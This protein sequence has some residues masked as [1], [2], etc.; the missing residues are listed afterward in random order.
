MRGSGM[1]PIYPWLRPPMKTGRKLR[2][3]RDALL[4]QER[5]AW[6]RRICALSRYTLCQQPER[7]QKRGHCR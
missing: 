7:P 2:A 4:V 1:K 5:T 6:A 3:G